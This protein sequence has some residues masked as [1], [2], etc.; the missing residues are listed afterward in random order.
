MRFLDIM[1]LVLSLIGILII[2]LSVWFAFSVSATG[3]NELMFKFNILTF[4]TGASYIL[5]IA[6]IMKLIKKDRVL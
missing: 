1:L 6:I 3:M 2:A 4:L 5:F